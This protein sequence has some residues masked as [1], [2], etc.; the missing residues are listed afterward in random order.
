VRYLSRQDGDGL[1]CHELFDS[2]FYDVQRG[3]SPSGVTAFEHWASGREHKFLT[4]ARLRTP[5]DP[6]P[7]RLIAR[8]VSFAKEF[9]VDFY[10]DLYREFAEYDE[11]AARDHYENHGKGEGR[12]GSAR[13]LL[14]NNGLAITDVPT[15][16]FPAEYVELHPDLEVWR[17]QP[18]RCLL[19]YLEHGR[20]ENRQIGYWQLKLADLR[21]DIP[22]RGL[23]PE[24][25]PPELR[26]RLCIL[27][28]VYY[29]E[30]WPEL[31]AFVSNLRT[32]SADVFINVT[33]TQWTP[34][35][36][37][38]LRELCPDAFVQ[39]SANRGRDIGGHF[40]LLDNVDIDRYEA[41]AFMHTKRSRHL[42]AE[43]GSGWRQSLIAA[44]AGNEDV[45]SECMRLFREQPRT[46]I[47]G[48][49]AW[50]AHSMNGN[51][52]EVDRLMARLRIE[53]RHRRLDF[54]SGT[55]FLIRSDVVLRL[56]RE[57]RDIEW[58]DPAGRDAA[59]FLDGQLEHA[60][61]RVIPSLARQMGYEIA[62]R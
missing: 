18:M 21:L 9:D 62:W 17:D 35:L 40:R 49:A 48:A 53:A 20:A 3:A 19:H 59:F 57:L 45:A 25:Q 47:V 8:A 26:H 14:S 10:R 38:Q 28:H 7:L 55:M 36:Q 1:R 30:L 16:F 22:A 43:R 41:F 46:G 11:F 39:L 37:E 58:E 50:R 23:V 4:D 60:V 6:V 34:Q 13:S 5:L 15:G 54:V 31:A 44:F 51:Q 42:A 33:D 12:H 32:V 61:E 2:Q 29:P 24:K 27:V 56:Y 52:V